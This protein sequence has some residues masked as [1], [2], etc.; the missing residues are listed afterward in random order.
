[1]PTFDDPWR[2]LLHR[3]LIEYNPLYLVSAA[4]VL[5]GVIHLSGG[6]AGGGTA[7]QLG[8]TAIA[9]VYAWSLIGGAALLVRIHLRRPA[10]MLV[11]LA[12]L[13][14][15]DLTLHT[16]TCAYL[17]VTGL[18]G[19]VGWWLSFV[20]KLRAL[21]WAIEVRVSRSAVMVMSAGAALIAMFPWV[22]RAVDGPTASSLLALALFGLFGAALWTRRAIEGRAPWSP[23]AATVARRS[24]RAIWTGFGAMVLLHVGFWLSQHPTLEAIALLP[25]GM[26]LA[27][28]W[29]ERES[30]VWLMVG[31][32][33]LCAGTALPHLLSLTAVM[34]ALT[35]GLHALGRPH[36]RRPR[37][38][39]VAPTAG[40]DVYRV[41][42]TAEP[43]APPPA[44]LPPIFVVPGRGERLRLLT[45]VA[46]CVYL[47]VWT[48]GWSGGPMP[49]HLAWLDLLLLV[50][51]LGAFVHGRWRLPLVL[52]GLASM[53][54]AIALELVSRPSTA[55]QWGAACIGVGFGLLLLCLIAS[56]HWRRRSA[57][58]HSSNADDSHGS[59]LCSRDGSRLASAASSQVVSS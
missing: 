3:W 6:L 8:I 19:S 28:R 32:T 43:A 14:Q 24:I 15:C 22:L 56:V 51:S 37:P 18:L 27:T 42:V 17:G 16:E 52:P 11:L 31:V 20:A 12:A 5:V 36:H 21:A 40:V 48:H 54:L 10:V 44:P 29:A 38:P 33:L 7:Q 59:P 9:E 1:M 55:L 23:W 45:G 53:H 50:A 2:R 26:L 57:R 25:A 39:V 41:D 58:L 49:P 46:G 47:A 4:L 13:Y 34:A 30:S 35:L